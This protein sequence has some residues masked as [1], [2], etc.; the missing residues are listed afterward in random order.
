LTNRLLRHDTPEHPVIRGL[1]HVRLLSDVDEIVGNTTLEV[2]G[3]GWIPWGA[4]KAL[5]DEFKVEYLEFEQLLIDTTAHLERVEDMPGFI[6]EKCLAEGR[7]TR[8]ARVRQHTGHQQHHTERAKRPPKEKPVPVPKPKKRK[9]KKKPPVPNN[10]WQP[11]WKRRQVRKT[12]RKKW[13]GEP[14]DVFEPK[15][16]EQKPKCQSL[17]LFSKPKRER[18]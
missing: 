12:R 4:A 3:E 8:F 15:K 1:V 14:D 6:C 2:G 10:V 7:I 17:N 5:H 11:Q 16:R 9:K 13:I 18:P